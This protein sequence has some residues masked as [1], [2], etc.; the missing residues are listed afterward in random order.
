MRMKEF[1]S[2]GVSLGRTRVTIPPLELILLAPP[3]PTRPPLRV[4]LYHT[5]I[6]ACVV[7]TNQL[8]N[9]TGHEVKKPFLV[10]Y[11]LLVL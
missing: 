7:S 9:G 4:T 8:R 1:L 2:L 11:C 3:L 6:A 10:G 5:D